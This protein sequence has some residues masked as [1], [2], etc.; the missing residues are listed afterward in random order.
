[1]NTMKKLFQ[2]LF[3]SLFAVSLVA[4]EDSEEYNADTALSPYEP[5]PGKRMVAQVK[6]TNN[7]GGR[8]YSW[9]HN[10][11][12]DAKGRIRE[13]N[14]KMV[15]YRAVEFDNVIRFYRCNITSK[16]NYYF[17]ENNRLSVY[18]SV[19]H[20]YPEFPDW[21]SADEGRDNGTF[22]DNGTLASFSALDFTYSATQLQHAY[23]D[24]GYMYEPS[25]N[26]SGDVTGYII[27]YPDNYDNDSIVLDRRGEYRFSSIRNK[28]NFDFSGYFGYWGLERAI[29]AVRTEYY[30][31]YQ[32]AAFGLLGAVSPNLP[33]HMLSRDSKGNAVKDNGG[34]PVYLTGKW[35]FDSKQCPVSFTDGSG[36]RTEIKYI[37]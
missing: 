28:T 12:Y 35:E 4:C 22:N 11:D 34:N 37:D 33:M 19:K 27:R 16:A 3:L 1:M 6:T 2:M 24:G 5:V 30:A 7:I 14:S 29:P 21:N 31:Y 9:E 20:E 10:F 32:I 15:H 23:A 13:I 25:R 17:L 8:E 26:S 36:R 18:Y